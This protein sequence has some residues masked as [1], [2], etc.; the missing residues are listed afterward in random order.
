MRKHIESG[1]NVEAIMEDWEFLQFRAA[2]YINSEVTGLPLSAQAR[3]DGIERCD[4]LT[5]FQPKRMLRGFCQRLK[6]KAG[7]FRG[8]LSGRSA[9]TRIG[10][11]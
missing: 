10:G 7:R 11:S 1:A 2:L 8:N 5:W 9:V 3:A 4:R 6:G